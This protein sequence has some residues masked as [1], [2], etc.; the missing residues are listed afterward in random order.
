[1]NE[2]TASLASKKLSVELLEFLFCDCLSHQIS[3]ASAV[4]DFYIYTSVE[5]PIVEIHAMPHKC[6]V[7]YNASVH[8]SAAGACL[9]CNFPADT[10]LS[11]EI[12][13]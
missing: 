6:F 3:D 9:E 13:G 7:L 11:D 8:A 2:R 1:M 10:F 5:G 4:M 12:L